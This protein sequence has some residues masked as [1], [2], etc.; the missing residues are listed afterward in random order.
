NFLVAAELA[1][2]L[3]LLVGASLTAKSLLRVIQADPGF[4]ATNVVAGSFSLPDNEY[5]TEEQKRNFIQQLVERAKALPGV[6][7]AGFKNPLLGGMQTGF[8]VE[9]RPKPEPGKA[10]TTDFSR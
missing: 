2:S 4:E 5:K 1:V 6:T 9:G 10:P 3:V 8:L 7:A